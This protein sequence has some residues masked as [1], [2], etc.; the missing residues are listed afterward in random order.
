M[1]SAGWS[2][3]LFTVSAHAQRETLLKPAVLAAVAVGP[4]DEAVPLAGA[5][6]RRIVLLTASEETLLHAQPHTH[7]HTPV[8]QTL[9]RTCT[10]TPNE[11]RVCMCVCDR[12]GVV[13]TLHP[14]QV[15]TP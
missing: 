8:G 11:P 13:H 3:S 9:G 1:I 12:R 2:S 10:N 4:V 6:V 5:G 7:T 15:I 14:S